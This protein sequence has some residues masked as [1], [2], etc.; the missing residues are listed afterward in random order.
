MSS[1]ELVNGFDLAN[2]LANGFDLKSRSV[3]MISRTFIHGGWS[4]DNHFGREKNARHVS[5]WLKNV[6][7]LL[8]KKIV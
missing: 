6:L 8:S 4:L 7:M 5:R 3:R 1:Q 2:G